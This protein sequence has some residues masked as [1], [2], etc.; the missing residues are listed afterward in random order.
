[1][2][3]HGAHTNEIH[4]AHNKSMVFPTVILMT[5]KCSMSLC[6]C[7]PK[8]CTLLIPVIVL[9]ACLVSCCSWSTYDWQRF[10]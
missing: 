1:M 2:L 7:A 6:V 4:D 3:F 8:E 10:V 9:F 5:Y